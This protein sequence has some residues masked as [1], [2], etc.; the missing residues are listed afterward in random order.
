MKQIVF[1]ATLLAS[2]PLIGQNLVPSDSWTVSSGSIGAYSQNGSSSMNVRETG[3]NPFGQQD[4]LWKAVPDAANGADG[5]WDTQ[6][7]TI[8]KNRM[9]RFAIWIKKT[10]SGD[11]TTYFGCRSNDILNLAGA[12]DSNPYFWYGDLPN[13]NKWYLLVGY[14]HA[15]NDPSTTHYGGVYDG[16]TGVKVL[17]VTDFKFSAS[18]TYSVHRTYLYYDTN[19]SDRQYFYDP[20]VY[21][22]EG[23]LPLEET[24]LADFK[25]GEVYF[26]KNVGIGTS[27]PQGSLDIKSAE[28]TIYLNGGEFGAIRGNEA[29]WL[30][31]YG[32]PQGSED[33]SIGTQDNTGS[34]TI[35]FATGGTAKMKILSNGNVGI[36][37]TTPDSKLTVKGT[38][39]TQEVKVD[40][41]GSV[42][43]DYVFEKDYTL[44]S[45]EE[46]KSYIDQNKH[47]PEVPS[48]QQMEEEGINL[49]EMNLLLLKKVEELTLHLLNQE[50]EIEI[51]K[52][53]VNILSSKIDH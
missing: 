8:D 20:Q 29:T 34:R 28:P 30:L 31:G 18:S 50:D 47:L 45:L 4:I 9:Y 14:V 36:G 53:K 26:N 3:A 2:L 6:N 41:N 24:I 48:A 11:G 51:L 16:E 1:I 12:V 27:N 46:L 43:P 17:S 52:Q 21:A 49:K 22:L 10:G 44:T 23:H 19:T 35:T 5:G 42:A 7:F 37:T 39:H 13:L 32:G 38:I 40:L 25:N 15:S 33:I